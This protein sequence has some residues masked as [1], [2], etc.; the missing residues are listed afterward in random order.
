[1]LY[2]LLATETRRVNIQTKNLAKNNLPKDNLFSV[3][4]MSRH[5]VILN[6]IDLVFGSIL[7]TDLIFVVKA[8][9]Y[10]YVFKCVYIK[11]RS[12]N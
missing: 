5:N 6:I 4:Q 10:V 3:C 12:Q 8:F 11:E 7:I 2:N 9:L 1:M